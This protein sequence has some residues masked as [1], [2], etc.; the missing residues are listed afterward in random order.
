[1]N[2]NLVY[3]LSVFAFSAPFLAIAAI[4][5]HYLLKR[6]AWRRKQRQGK[7]ISGF[8]PSSAALGFVFLFV[9]VLYRPGVE[10]VLLEQQ[11]E[12]VEEDGAGDPES[13]AKQLTRQ[14]KRIRH[15][16]QI[17]TLVLRLC[18]EHLPETGIRRNG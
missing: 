12:D 13:P 7:K 3:D 2:D 6:A 4:L 17:D 10:F 5:V 15:G 16:E 18:A 9:Q 14:L 11:R 8:C 1:M